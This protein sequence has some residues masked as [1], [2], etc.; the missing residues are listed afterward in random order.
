MNWHF[1]FRDV[2]DEPVG[3]GSGP[4]FTT[5]RRESC[6]PLWQQKSLRSLEKLASPELANLL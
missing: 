2:T 1:T 5:L 4:I 6:R 3:K